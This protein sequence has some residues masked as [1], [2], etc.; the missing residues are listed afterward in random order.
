MLLDLRIR[1]LAP[2]RL[3]ARESPFLIGAHKP[4]VACHIGGENGGQLAFDAFRGQSG[5]PQPH[6]PNK[7][8]ALRTHSN[9]KWEG[10]HFLSVKPP[11]WFTF[12]VPL[13]AYPAP[14]EIGSTVGG[15]GTG[16]STVTRS[17]VDE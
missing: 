17:D 9:G 2:K 13:S 15:W 16:L 11:V 7:L 1:Q 3:Q 12:S 8:S 4:R 5:I 6:G 14:D 10:W